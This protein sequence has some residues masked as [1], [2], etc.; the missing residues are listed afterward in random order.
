MKNEKKDERDKSISDTISN[1]SAKLYAL[2]EL[3]KFRDA[4]AISI[5]EGE[6]NYGI[7]NPKLKKKPK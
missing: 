2:G 5:D 3:I 1:I 4:S 7:Q 6:V